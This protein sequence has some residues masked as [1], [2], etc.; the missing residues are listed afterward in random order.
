M[1]IIEQSQKIDSLA[2]GGN[3][4]VTPGF[5]PILRSY[6]LLSKSL[7]CIFT[8]GYNKDVEMWRYSAM[9][10]ELSTLM[11]YIRQE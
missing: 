11:A 5:I 2:F 3:T 4:S 9:E 7:D 6:L 8:F 1:H 10:V